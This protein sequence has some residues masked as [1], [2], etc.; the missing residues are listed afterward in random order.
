MH[1][2]LFV[3]NCIY[4][5]ICINNV[6]FVE[7]LSGETDQAGLTASIKFSFSLCNASPF[8][9]VI[10]LGILKLSLNSP[11]RVMFCFSKNEVDSIPWR[12]MEFFCIIMITFLFTFYMHCEAVHTCRVDIQFV[13]V[14]STCSLQAD[15]S[16]LPF[17]RMLRCEEEE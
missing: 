4:K 2:S 16:T 11:T 12:V 5:R 10:I 3:F 7:F 15:E 14:S 8:I 6:F 17:K 9:G 13:I 1:G